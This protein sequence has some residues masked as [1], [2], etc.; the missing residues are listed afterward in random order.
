MRTFSVRLQ[1][2]D[3]AGRRFI[4]VEALLDTGSSDTMLPRDM[5][6]ALGVVPVE[7][8]RFELADERVEEYD[9]G[10]IRIRLDGRERTT[11]VVFGPEGARSLLGASTLELFHLAVDPVRR[12]LVAVPGLLK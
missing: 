6:L 10:E 3:P 2:G 12:R 11:A 5:L 1:V 7:R 8:Q 4:E 9:V